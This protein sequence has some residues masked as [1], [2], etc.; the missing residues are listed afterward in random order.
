MEPTMSVM[1]ELQISER[2]DAVWVHCSDGSTV[3]RF[4][5][6]GIDIHNSITE[7]LE[8]ASQCK[9]CTHGRVSLN[10]WITFREKSLELWGVNVPEDAFNPKYFIA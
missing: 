4:G 9:L 3:G 10:D 2:K 5:V 8:G 7:Q 1:F 6:F